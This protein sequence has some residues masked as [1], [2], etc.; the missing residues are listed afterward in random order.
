L[1][2]IAGYFCLKM[3]VTAGVLVFSSWKRFGEDLFMPLLSVSSQLVGH[4]AKLRNIG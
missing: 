1:A 2:G 3:P 4:V